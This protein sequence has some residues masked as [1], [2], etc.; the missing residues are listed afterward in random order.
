MPL[1]CRPRRA[2]THPADVVRYAL[3]CAGCGGIVQEED[4]EGEGHLIHPGACSQSHR[5]EL[6]KEVHSM[7]Q[8]CVRFGQGRAI[9][10]G[11][12]VGW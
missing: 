9:H 5:G 4:R 6:G 10:A 12:G 3:L 11:A 1:P 2:C 7:G 8:H